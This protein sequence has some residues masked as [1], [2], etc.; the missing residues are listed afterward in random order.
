MFSILQTSGIQTTEG[1]LISSGALKACKICWIVGKI[2]TK[3]NPSNNKYLKKLLKNLPYF[4]RLLNLAAGLLNSS[5]LPCS[6]KLFFSF[7]M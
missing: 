2:I 4:L 1:L 3:H 6:A 7:I 5:I